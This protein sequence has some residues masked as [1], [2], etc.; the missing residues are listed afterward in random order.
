VAVHQ[1]LARAQRPRPSIRTASSSSAPGRSRRTRSVVRGR[2]DL[3][4]RPDLLERVTARRASVEPGTDATGIRATDPPEARDRPGLGNGRD[5]RAAGR[6]QLW[7]VPAAA[8]GTDPPLRC[9]LRH[10][11]TPSALGILSVPRGTSE[12]APVLRGATANRPGRTW[13][14][15]GPGSG[16]VPRG[17]TRR[18]RG[19]P[20]GVRGRCGEFPGRTG[21]AVS[22]GGHAPSES[23]SSAGR[24]NAALSRDHRGAL[25]GPTA[26]GGDSHE[27]AA[28][29]CGARTSSR[30][31]GP[32]TPIDPSSRR[33]R[34]GP[35]DPRAGEVDR[36]SVPLIIARVGRSPGKA[37]PTVPSRRP[38]I[39]WCGAPTTCGR[40]AGRRQPSSQ[41]RSRVPRTALA[42]R[43]SGL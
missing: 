34:A 35:G 3:T 40:G 4:R 16:H 9:P 41:H 8:L 29:W 11:R 2:P 36:A 31:R 1:R 12:I 5:R 27:E 14:A 24:A 13:R 17:T 32:E 38:S 37:A 19:G 23:S 20:A 39:C 30:R 6:H 42:R 7:R 15:G 22:F 10:L 21:S 43:S 25:T 26:C 18:S 28:T 33:P